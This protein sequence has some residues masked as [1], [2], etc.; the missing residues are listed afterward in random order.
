[1][2]KENKNI[3][4]VI[5]FFVEKKLDSEEILRRSDSF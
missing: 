1:M 2:K 5:V 4:V 3:W